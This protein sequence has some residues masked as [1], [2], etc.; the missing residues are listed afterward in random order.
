MSW[1]KT[2]EKERQAAESNEQ[3]RAAV[4][5]EGAKELASSAQKIIEDIMTD[6]RN[7][8]AFWDDTEEGRKRYIATLL[9]EA[10]RKLNLPMDEVKK[11]S[12][13]DL[14]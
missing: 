13:D 8:S 3:E 5:D 6:E 10:V 1:E 2:E 14:W 12:V 11:A 7:K 4:I 9:H